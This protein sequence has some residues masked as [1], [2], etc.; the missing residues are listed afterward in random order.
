M[1]LLGGSVGGTNV[2]GRVGSGGSGGAHDGSGVGVEREALRKR[3]TDGVA[4]VSGGDGGDVDVVDSDV[5][6]EV[7]VL[8]DDARLQGRRVGAVEKEVGELDLA[9]ASDAHYS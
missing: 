9:S 1:D 6:L 3:G 8:V 2:V 5:E 4:V 7:R